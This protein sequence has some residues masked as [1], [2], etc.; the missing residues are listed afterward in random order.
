MDMPAFIAG[1][2]EGTWSQIRRQQKSVGFFKD[3]FYGSWQP[4]KPDAESR[5]DV[6]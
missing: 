3:L 1:G 4:T 2:G 6:L 5:Q